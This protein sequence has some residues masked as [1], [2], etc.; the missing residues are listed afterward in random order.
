MK[1][2]IKTTIKHP[3]LGHLTMDQVNKLFVDSVGK[4][5]DGGNCILQGFMRGVAAS[6]IQLNSFTWFDCLLYARPMDLDTEKLKSLWESWT[7]HCVRLS[8]FKR[9]DGVYD[10]TPIFEVIY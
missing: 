9:T 10:N 6:V 5:D 2:T 4:S 1:K 8:K 3:K 7:D